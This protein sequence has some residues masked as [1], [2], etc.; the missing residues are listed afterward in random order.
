[1][2]VCPFCKATTA[3]SHGPCAKC[4]KVAADHP[5]IAGS[6]GRTLPAAAPSQPEIPAQPP[7]PEPPNHAATIAKYPAPPHAIWQAPVY[8]IKVILRQFELRQDLESLR[9]RRSPD[10][11]LYEAALRAYE[12]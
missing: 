4:G 11:P 8:A 7:A 10:V 12:K 2:A 1:M 6:A 3:T 5:S 9:R